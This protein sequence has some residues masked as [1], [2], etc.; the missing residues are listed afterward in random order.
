MCPGLGTRTWKDFVCSCKYL[1]LVAPAV[2][3]L[4]RDSAL[5][6]RCATPSPVPQPHKLHSP[7][8]AGVGKFMLPTAPA[9]RRVAK[10]IS[11]RPSSNNNTSAIAAFGER[12][13]L[14]DSLESSFTRALALQVVV[15][16]GANNPGDASCL[17][18]NGVAQV[19][20]FLP[21]YIV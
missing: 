11:H 16:Y 12:D 21:R 1:G 5:A 19:E 15:Q 7:D 9:V 13:V 6:G 17:C 8:S 10:Q 18:R 4:G 3:N 20:D 2:I 14:L